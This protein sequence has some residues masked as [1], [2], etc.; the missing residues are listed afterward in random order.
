[1]LVMEEQRTQTQTVLVAVEACISSVV[2][3]VLV[4]AVAVLLEMFSL[5]SRAGVPHREMLA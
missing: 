5:L 4:L 2:Q 3:L 1:M